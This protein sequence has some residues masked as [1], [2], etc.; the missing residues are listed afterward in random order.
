MKFAGFVITYKRKDILK[1]TIFKIFSQTFP[2]EKLLIVDNSPDDN[3]ELMISKLK[4]S[5][6]QYLKVGNNSGPAGAAF[7]ALKTLTE[8]GY[9]YVYWGD[10]NDPP[11]NMHIFQRLI[12]FLESESNIGAIGTDG[13]F[14]YPNLAWTKNIS[15]KEIIGLTDVDYIPGGFNFI[16]NSKCVKEGILPTPKLFFGFEE[17]DFCLKIKKAGYRVVIDGDFLLCLRKSMNNDSIYYRKKGVS[18]GRLSQ[19]NRNYYSLRNMLFVLKSNKKKLGCVF[20]ILKSLLKIFFGFFYGYKYGIKN[21]RVIFL[22]LFDFL[23]NKFGEKSTIEK[24]IE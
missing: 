15:N 9:D 24:L 8:Q 16:I 19:L 17:L 10:D 4:I 13:G 18:F 1:E 12:N 7:L 5:N 23:A 20:L 2:P 14:F 21:L 22:A 11:V 3:T 6:I